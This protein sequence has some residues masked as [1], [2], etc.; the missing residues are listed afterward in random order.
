MQR[1]TPAHARLLSRRASKGRTKQ[2]APSGA[3]DLCRLSD[4]VRRH[5]PELMCKLPDKNLIQVAEDITLENSDYARR[6]RLGDERPACVASTA[7]V[8]TRR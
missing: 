3:R 4:G 5:R 2:N 7:S 8:T 6:H 1:K